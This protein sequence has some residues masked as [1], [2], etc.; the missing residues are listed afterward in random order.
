MPTVPR[1][2]ITTT[3]L[4]RLPGVQSVTPHG[5]EAIG[6][7]AAAL[8][9]Q[10]D[11]M[12]DLQRARNMEVAGI[13]R[14]LQG[15]AD[16]AVTWDR[17]QRVREARQVDEAETAALDHMTR[18]VRGYQDPQTGQYVPGALDE[19]YDPD[20]QATGEPRTASGATAK[21]YKEWVDNQDGAF[22][23]LS[24]RAQEQFKQRFTP[25]YRMFE[26]TAFA[27]DRD[28]D[29]ERR[30]T[31]DQTASAAALDAINQ[32]APN[33]A[34]WRQALP[35]F[36]T[37]E[38]MR[39]NRHLMVNPD[40]ATEADIKWRSEGGLAAFN[41]TK[42]EI[43]TT[44]AGR[45]VEALLQLADAA[46]VGSPEADAQAAALLEGAQAFAAAFTPTGSTKP[47]LNP[48]Q[49]AKV[50]EAAAAI[51]AER[52][53]KTAGQEADDIQA[54]QKLAVQ[55]ASQSLKDFAPLQ[56]A[57]DK[58]KGP[59]RADLGQ[60]LNQHQAMQRRDDAQKAWIKYEANPTP[61][62][63]AELQ[64]AIDSNPDPA[65]QVYLRD[66]LAKHAMQGGMKKLDA[67]AVAYQGYGL[68]KDEWDAKVIPLLK[69]GSARDFESYLA[70]VPDEAVRN[71]LT[72]RYR[73]IADATDADFART[74]ER[75][76]KERQA[77]ERE[78]ALAFLELG[79]WPTGDGVRVMNEHE[80]A[81]TAQDL[82]TAGT[83][84][85]S[86]YL[87]LVKRLETAKDAAQLSG[88]V[89]ELTKSTLG[90]SDQDMQQLAKFHTGAGRFVPANKK[91]GV[92]FHADAKTFKVSVDGRKGELTA[93]IIRKL[94][95]AGLQ[96]Q[97]QV[98]VEG[99]GGKPADLQTVLQSM[100]SP[101]DPDVKALND[102]IAEDN[103]QEFQSLITDMEA[104]RATSGASA[105]NQ[106]K[107]TASN[108]TD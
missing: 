43:E 52:K 31:L 78:R 62:A 9:R 71:D 105:I 13:Q 106:R 42:R 93:K 35:V 41:Q 27:R 95:N 54:A 28:N 14:G 10:A 84:K 46:P 11:A 81:R 72:L 51:A 5:A 108:A 83:I 40:A 2:T 96:Y 64:T 21:A 68:P 56:A 34:A 4:D 30:K 98:K 74:V 97:M 80:I 50:K 88:T 23:R 103:L 87:G 6:A 12:G 76:T 38:A 33:E 70:S 45:R 53:R 24:P 37:S 20:G 86:D 92:P 17:I 100:L 49:I 15:I 3:R 18:R 79:A 73:S 69:K 55:W 16:S 75:Q 94:L 39:R 104:A 1:N 19:P 29:L 8:G 89:I 65:A 60:F 99:K 59:A 58:L 82:A 47:A 26:E 57:W 7:Q 25:K 101:E 90:L 48:E 32:A 63:R 77:S 61:A 67:F 91:P 102:Q 66:N 44:A 22:A 107:G 85:P 36:A